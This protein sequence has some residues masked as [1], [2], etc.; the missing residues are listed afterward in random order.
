MQSRDLLLSVSLDAT[1][2][3]YTTLEF[4]F[5]LSYGR[6]TFAQPSQRVMSV[7]HMRPTIRLRG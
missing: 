1:L 3:A 6:I 2:Q 5:F 7:L 4:D